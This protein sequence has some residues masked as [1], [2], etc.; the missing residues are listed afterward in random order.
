[1]VH[2]SLTDHRAE[3]SEFVRQLLHKA[4]VQPAYA[5]DDGL[6]L[7]EPTRPD[8][9]DVPTQPALMLQAISERQR[10]RADY[11]AAQLKAGEAPDDDRSAHD[12][13]AA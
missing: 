10:W 1:V 2:K 7:W 11:L 12:Q 13:E 4:G 6:F 8:D 5:V 3:R 9:T